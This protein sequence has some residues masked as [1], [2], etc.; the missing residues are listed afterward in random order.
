MVMV[1]FKQKQF[2]FDRQAV[3]EAVGRASATN[4]SKAGSFIRRS[5]RSSLRRRK[6][7]SDPGS[8]PSIH[9][10]DPVATLKNIWFVFDPGNRSVIVGPLNLNSSS[11]E[12]SD[13][14]SVPSLHELGG[15]TL[16]GTKK[17]RRRESWTRRRACF[18][19]VA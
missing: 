14:V 16:V 2:F 5:A 3:I 1:G 12:G 8:P 18:F 6:K 19:V 15:S 4:L 7:V 9:S 11:L 13:R 10:K 17:Q